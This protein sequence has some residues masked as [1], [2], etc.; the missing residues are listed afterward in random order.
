MTETIES[1]ALVARLAARDAF[2]QGLGLELLEAGTGWAALALTV[3]PEHLN[4]NGT[5]HGGLLFTLADTAFGLAANSHGAVAIGIDAHMTFSA[6][7]KPGDRVVA[8]AKELTRG[9]RV[10]TYRIT[11]T[12]GDGK[13]IGGLTGTVLLPGEHHTSGGAETPAD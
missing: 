6:A 9:R 4:F 5:C 2:V 10:A 13:V 1:A 8:K 11:L 12:R 7:A 3:K